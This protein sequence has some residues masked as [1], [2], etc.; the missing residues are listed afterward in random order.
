MSRLASATLHASAACA[1][2]IFGKIS[3]R[4]CNP[5][6]WKQDQEGA[7]PKLGGRLGQFVGDNQA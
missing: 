7:D 4:I 3:K 5:T 1:L 6:T 2:K